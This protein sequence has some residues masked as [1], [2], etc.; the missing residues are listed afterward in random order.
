MNSHTVY[1]VVY[2]GGQFDFHF[3]K[4]GGERRRNGRTNIK[5]GDGVKEV[6]KIKGKKRG[7][8]KRTK[9]RGGGGWK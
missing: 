5:K 9:N 4:G 6:K 2:T 8:E 1:D 3:E 7:G